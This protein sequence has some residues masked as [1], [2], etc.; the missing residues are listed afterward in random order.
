MDGEKA[1]RSIDEL[2]ADSV[3]EAAAGAAADDTL[4]TVAWD[5]F[6]LTILLVV[7]F[8]RNAPGLAREEKIAVWLYKH[9]RM[10]IQQASCVGSV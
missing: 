1:D 9:I 6:L 5:D 10:Y 8:Q 7:C 2:V 4:E 3:D